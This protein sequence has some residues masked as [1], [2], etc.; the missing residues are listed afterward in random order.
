MAVTG[1]GLAAREVA[2]VA[3]VHPVLRR[4]DLLGLFDTADLSGD[5]I[6]VSPFVRDTAD[7]TVSVAWRTA[8][9]MTEESVASA[10]GRD[11]VCPAPIAA[12]RAL[13]AGQRQAWIFDQDDGRW[14]PARAGDVRPT[15]IVVLAADAGGYRPDVGFAAADHTPVEPVDVPA[16][17]DT[18]PQSV[19]AARWARLGEHL[20]GHP[21]RGGRAAR[22]VRRHTWAP[23]ERVGAARRQATGVS[24]PAPQGR[25]GRRAG[26]ATAARPRASS[27]RRSA[28]AAPSGRLPA[29]SRS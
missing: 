8:E 27:R 28:R 4:R 10:V 23:P 9:A 24:R 11:E 7:R 14:R 18:D 15:A 25:D 12:V 26:R 1:A 29:E 6:D 22:R 21:A 2:Q 5:D 17:V 19:R 20:A 3:P 13:V 16:A